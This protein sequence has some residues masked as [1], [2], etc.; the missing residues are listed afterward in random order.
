[1]LIAHVEASGVWLLDGGMHALARALETLAT[2]SGARFRYDSPV[3]EILVEQ[4]RAVGVVLASGERLDAG[5]IIC[6]A[7]PAAIADGR[8]GAA[9]STAVP[10][11]EREARSLA[12][13]VWTAEAQTSGFPLL[14]HNVI[15]SDDY[16]AEF[17]QLAANRLPDPPTVYVCAQDRDGAGNGPDG[18]E[19]LQILV[20]APPIGDGPGFSQAEIDQCQVRMLESLRRAGLSV[21]LSPAATTLT[22]PMGL[23]HAVPLDGW[24]PLWTGLAR[25]GRRPSVGPA[26]GLGSLVFIARAGARTR[27]LASRWRRSAAA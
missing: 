9:A 8:F 24:S 10:P 20:N 18:P 2:R 19:R 15:F 13:M 1:M 25:D 17:D 26:P 4:G 12:A 6:N 21:V 7:D 3:Q 27:A 23:R 16:A 22:T 5:S 14:H 11:T